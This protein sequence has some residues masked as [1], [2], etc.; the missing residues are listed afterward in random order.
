MG[1][2]GEREQGSRGAGERSSL[3][4]QHST[5][6]T[7]YNTQHS[8]LHTPHFWRRCLPGHKT[9]NYLSAWLALT[10]AQQYGAKEA[11][12]VDE[13]GNWLETS[14]GNLWGW[15]E[16]RW[17]TPPLEA[18]ILPGV[19]RSHLLDW[20][21]TQNREV[22]QVPWDEDFVS[23]LS[24]IAYT[25]SVVQVVPIR[26]A[27]YGDR[28]ITFDPHHPALKLLRRLFEQATHPG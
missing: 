13:G 10:Q 26:E 5:L 16:G 24:A 23:G 3:N 17:W 1:R 2:A 19:V 11:I 20:L 21:Q 4:T 27:I 25:N 15:R 18:G 12:L 9:G 8:T 28:K 6:H 14:T 22:G 7:S